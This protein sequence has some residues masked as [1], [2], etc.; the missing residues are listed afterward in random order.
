M[1]K[2][3]KGIKK[4]NVTETKQSQMSDAEALANGL[5][6]QTSIIDIPADCKKE[7]EA[8]G[9]E[10]RWIDLVQYKKNYGFH[11]R[12]WAPFKFNC[13]SA[14]NNPFV[15]NAGQFDGYLIRKQLILAAKPVEKAEAR[16]KY[17]EARTKMQSN[18]GKTSQEELLRALQGSGLEKTIKGWDDRDEKET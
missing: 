4:A 14:A 13:L 2:P 15:E 8:A 16:R 9:L 3:V 18:P 17:N 1:D 10:A 7:L 12:E 6:S 11:K 5:R